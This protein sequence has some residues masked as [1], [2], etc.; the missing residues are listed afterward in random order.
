MAK[1]NNSHS[2]YTV[3]IDLGG[4][5][6]LAAVVDAGGNVVATAKRS[7]K[8]EVGPEGV[9]ER[10]IKTIED[11]LA[12]VKMSKEQIAATGIGVPGP[13][14]TR[15]GVALSVTN[16]PGWVNV[17]VADWLRRWHDV[18][19]VL[20]NDVRAA[21]MGELM[22]GAG[23]GLHHFVAVFIGTGIGG[24]IVING[25][26]YEGAR[27]SAG[28]IG[29][30]VTMADGPYAEG[31]GIRGGIEAIASRSAIERDLRAALAAGRKSI[32]PQL[33]AKKDGALTSS[34]LAAAVEKGDPLTVEVLQRAAH[35]LGLHAASLINCFDPQALVYGGGVIEALGEWM[36]GP[37]RETAMQHLINRARVE[38]V[39]IV[40]AKLGDRAGV[41]GAALLAKGALQ[42]EVAK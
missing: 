2:A 13:V 37:I 5:K 25:Q 31:G 16:M 14:D 4:T 28:E 21:C 7:T 41:V 18:P 9:I 12:G 10:V 8:A 29:H 1:R 15:S 39:R 32:L 22:L 33:M 36:L 20:T 6:I 40:E 35:Y 19:V 3:G 34:V 30:M 23:Q 24:G 11:A 26:I 42:R 17:P 27:G 38:E